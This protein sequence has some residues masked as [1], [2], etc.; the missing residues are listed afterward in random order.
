MRRTNGNGA[1]SP[2]S[3]VLAVLA[4]V[5]CVISLTACGSSGK[6]DSRS[7]ASGDVVGIKLADCMRAHGLPNFP[8]PTAGGGIQLPDGVNPQAPAF[9]SALNVCSKLMPGAGAPRG[10][11]SEKRKLAM[12]TLAQ[13]M[14]KHGLLSFPDP[15][16][17]APSPGAGFGIAFGGP[18]SFI[19]VP[20]S[21]MQSPAFNQ[22]AATCN[23]PG[24]G[25]GGGGKR[26][27]AP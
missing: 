10:P 12:L 4:V 20:Q 26:A 25:R 3:V 24:F 21:L 1:P 17:T 16:T 15:T 14:R 27:S 22:A 11:V 6:S 2:G 23:F 8:D 9:Q 18:G 5:S 13:C 19:A 7:G